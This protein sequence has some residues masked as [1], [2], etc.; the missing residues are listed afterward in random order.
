[1]RRYGLL[2]AGGY[3]RVRLPHTPAS[4][5]GEDYINASHVNVSHV[6]ASCDIHAA[7]HPC[8]PPPQGYRAWNAYIATQ[9][10]LKKTTG[11]FWRMVLERGSRCI[12]MLCRLT[13]GG[14]VGPPHCTAAL[15]GVP[16]HEPLPGRPPFRRPATA[17][18]QEER[19]ALWTMRG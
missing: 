2:H 16:P 10:P 17:T 18:G 8:P 1:M 19:V 9:G 5:E 4:E 7:P 15:P 6:T 13:E 14:K 3:Y 11:D 12:V